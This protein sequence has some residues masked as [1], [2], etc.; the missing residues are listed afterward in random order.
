MPM[1]SK[2]LSDVSK[3]E[4][5]KRKKPKGGAKKEGEIKASKKKPKSTSNSS[6]FRGEVDKVLKVRD[7]TPFQT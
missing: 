5:K 2:A 1:N 3:V 6:G 4:K 7:P